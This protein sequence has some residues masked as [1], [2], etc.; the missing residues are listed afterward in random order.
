MEI[1][2]GERE[3]EA[4]LSPCCVCLQ[5]RCRKVLERLPLLSN[6]IFIRFFLNI[7]CQIA[8]ISKLKGSKSWQMA[9]VWATSGA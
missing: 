8:Y 6:V 7:F 1:P 3:D 5:K 9:G 2:S 4:A